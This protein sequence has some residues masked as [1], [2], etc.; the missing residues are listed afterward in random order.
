MRMAGITLNRAEQGGLIATVA[1]VI[2]LIGVGIAGVET[3]FWVAYSDGSRV[4]GFLLIGF[5]LAWA[6]LSAV[7]SRTKF[8]SLG[9]RMD[10]DKFGI[11][12]AVM[13]G[14]AVLIIAL[15]QP[16]L[17]R[18]DVAKLPPDPAR[19]ERTLRVE[20]NFRVYVSMSVLLAG[21][22]LASIPA[23]RFFKR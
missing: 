23:I 4:A 1:G 19:R 11:T 13:L 22:A 7:T 6:T 9:T 10:A 14:V 17:P 3:G 8:F 16:H 15:L 2:L 12:L 5:G 18:S 21:V 20:S